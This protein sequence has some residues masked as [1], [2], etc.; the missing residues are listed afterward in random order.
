M[1]IPLARILSLPNGG[2]NSGLGVSHAARDGAARR[3]RMAAAPQK[4]ADGTLDP[5]AT[6]VLPVFIGR[7]TRAVQFAESGEKEYLAL[8]QLGVTTDTQDMWGNILE[9]KPVPPDAWERL[10]DL[11]PFKVRAGWWAKRLSTGRRRPSASPAFFLRVRCSK[12]TYIRTLCHDLGQ[13]LGCGG[14]MASLRRTRQKGAMAKMNAVKK[15]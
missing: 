14:C 9:K 7:A 12:G 15:A 4:G 13:A 5:M 1:R 3:R 11:L 8:L 10:N 6:G 2:Q